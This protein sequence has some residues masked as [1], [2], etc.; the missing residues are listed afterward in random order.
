VQRN[1]PPDVILRRHLRQTTHDRHWEERT[2][3]R[4]IGLGLAISLVVAAVPQVAGAGRPIA[5][6]AIGIQTVE[7]TAEFVAESGYEFSGFV[8]TG[9]LDSR[10]LISLSETNIAGIVRSVYCAPRQIAADDGRLMNGLFMHVF[11]DEA[12]PADSVV[13]VNFYQERMA[14]NPATAIPC[15]GRC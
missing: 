7:L 14:T 1:D 13:V 4:L 12:I 3:R 15:D 9:S 10:C 11:A 5:I 2:M 6:A 8:E